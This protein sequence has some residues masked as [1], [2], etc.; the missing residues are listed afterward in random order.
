MEVWH[1]G[2][3]L[4]YYQALNALDRRQKERREREAEERRRAQGA[5]N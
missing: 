4:G 2:R 1:K 5:Q 3:W